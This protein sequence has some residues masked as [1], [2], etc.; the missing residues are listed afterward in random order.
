MGLNQMLG[1]AT[2]EAA[3]GIFGM[4][5]FPLPLMSL[6][7]GPP[8]SPPNATAEKTAEL[9]KAQF[10]DWEST[11]KPIELQAL[12]Q[13][14]LNNSAVLPNALNEAKE[15]V[16]DAYGA[17]P[18]IMERQNRGLG[19]NPTEQQKSITKRVMNVNQGAATAG[20]EN[21]ARAG[22]RQLDEELLMGTTPNPNIAKATPLHQ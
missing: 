3:I 12:Q 1:G 4:G 21:T 17:L 11:F 16:S 7:E 19:I 22:V 10:A 15:N 9:L 20:A 5:G 18:G 6:F 14:S 8:D 13:V 2:G